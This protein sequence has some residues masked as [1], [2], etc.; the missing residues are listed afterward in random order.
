M[1]SIVQAGQLDDYGL[2]PWRARAKALFCCEVVHATLPTIT[3]SECSRSKPDYSWSLA[4]KFPVGTTQFYVFVN[5]VFSLYFLFY[6]SLINPVKPTLDRKPLVHTARIYR[7]QR[8][9]NR[10]QNVAGTAQHFNNGTAHHSISLLRNGNLSKAIRQVQ[11]R[12]YS[13]QDV[14]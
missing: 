1:S 8:A 14:D 10:S 12:N 4:H 3:S 7:P 2:G 11:A 13:Q 9:A 5:G 6:L